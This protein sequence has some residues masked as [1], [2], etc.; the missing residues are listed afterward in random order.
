MLL[1]SVRKLLLSVCRCG[2]FLLTFLFSEH[3][4][5]FVALPDP[6]RNETNIPRH[7]VKRHTAGV[8]SGGRGRG[9]W[10]IAGGT[11]DGS[12]GWPTVGSLFWGHGGGETATDPSPKLSLSQSLSVPFPSSALSTLPLPR[13]SSA[14]SVNRCPPHILEIERV[15]DCRSASRQIDRSFFFSRSKFRSSFLYDSLLACTFS[16]G[17]PISL[18]GPCSARLSGPNAPPF[19]QNAP[20]EEVVF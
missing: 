17:K 8:V 12:G 1:S 16:L 4:Q 13:H 2:T 9:W 6:K 5:L 3:R 14:P 15:D 11:P 7:D 19:S 18:N 20:C 10:G